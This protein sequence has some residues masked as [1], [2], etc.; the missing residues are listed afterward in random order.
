MTMRQLGLICALAASGC[1]ASTKSQSARTEGTDTSL[2]SLID[3]NAEKEDQAIIARNQC[4]GDR[5]KPREC[6]SDN[7]C[8]EGFYCGRD[9][10]ISDVIKVCM[11]ISQ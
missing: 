8:C 6:E 2:S 3:D 5:N 10:Q 4:V 9:P 11:S 1:G 7:E